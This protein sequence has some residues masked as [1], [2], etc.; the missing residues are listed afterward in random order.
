VLSIDLD[1]VRARYNAL[2]TALGADLHF[3]VKANAHPSVLLTLRN[4]GAGFDI[5][6]AEEARIV[7]SLGVP[8]DRMLFSAP[9]RT[10]HDV[11]VARQIGVTQF[12]ADSGDEVA[13]L[14]RVA[15]Q[16]D[17]I[18]RLAVDSVGSRWSLSSKF[19][20]AIEHLPSLAA[21]AVGAGLRVAGV[22]FHVGSQAESLAVWGRAIHQA[23]RAL[24]LLASEGH[25]PQLLNVGGGFPVQ[26][27]RPVPPISE[28]AA[29]ITRAVDAFA[30]FPVRLVAEPGRYLVAEAGR[31]RA[32]VVST[33]LRG[34]RR[35]IYLNVGSFNGLFEAGRTGGSLPLPIRLDR[36]ATSDHELLSVFAG[37]SCDGDDVLG[38]ERAFPADVRGGDTVTIGNAGAYSLSYV[39]PLCGLV[40]LAVQ[41]TTRDRAA[42]V[43]DGFRV[44]RVRAGDD[45]LTICT[46]IEAEVFSRAGYLGEDGT[47]DEFRAYDEQSVFVLVEHQGK[48][49]AC[50]RE[51]VPGPLEFKTV[52]D[53]ELFPLAHPW[54]EQ[55]GR[56]RVAEVG[57]VATLPD[58]RGLEAA[59]WCYV[60]GW[61]GAVARGTTHWVASIDSRLLRYFRESYGFDFVDIGPEADYFGSL[62]TPVIM[63][64]TTAAPKVMAASEAMRERA[65]ATP[66]LDFDLPVR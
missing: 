41:A 45:A 7:A 16:V 34:D 65:I 52:K 55:I 10:D 61:A 11:E 25:E 60:V 53:F 31:V 27:D 47:L 30:P 33:S 22:S 54:L 5:A 59:Q 62:T 35:W 8:P 57:T 24:E 49:V 1:V 51:V 3:A 37:A 63:D 2:K 39:T 50:L 46:D 29:E 48:P 19:G 23:A 20:A 17:V 43:G 56:P 13:R 38:E 9:V 21:A 18:L 6:S 64:L 28:V 42:D 40:P 44:R 26:Y 15:G 66:L 14:G 12:V 36:P 32:E 4:A 58:S